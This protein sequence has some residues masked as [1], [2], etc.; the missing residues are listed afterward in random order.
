MNYI[1]HSEDFIYFNATSSEAA[2][3]GAVYTQKY[4]GYKLPINKDTLKDIMFY[5]NH[6][7]LTELLPQRD[8]GR[9][10]YKDDEDLEPCNANSR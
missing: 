10:V 4:R 3:L 6:Q 5:I 2:K 8:N 9:S 7:K 1:G